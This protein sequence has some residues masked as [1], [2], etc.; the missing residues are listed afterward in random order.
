MIKEQLRKRMHL[1]IEIVGAWLRR[2]MEGHFRDF[3]VPGKQRSYRDT[4]VTALRSQ[5]RTLLPAARWAHS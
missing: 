3:A 2:V 1:A 5:L 4:G